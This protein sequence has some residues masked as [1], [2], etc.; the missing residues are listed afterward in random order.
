MFPFGGGGIPELVAFVAVIVDGGELLVL[1]GMLYWT[2]PR[3]LFG[4]MGIP[5]EG[6]LLGM[7]NLEVDKLGIFEVLCIVLDAGI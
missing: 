3:R 7:G 1:L 6:P 2:V 5:E 4:D